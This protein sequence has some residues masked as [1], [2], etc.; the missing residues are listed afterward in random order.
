MAARSSS[1]LTVGTAT[2]LCPM[3]S[4]VRCTMKKGTGLFPCA[5]GLH[6]RFF[7]FAFDTGSFV[8]FS[9]ESKS[10]YIQITMAMYIHIKEIQYEK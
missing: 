6:L 5:A 2:G 4:Y 8:G 3:P 7:F 10:D 9:L 1:N